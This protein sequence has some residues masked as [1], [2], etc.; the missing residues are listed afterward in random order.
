MRNNGLNMLKAL[1]LFFPYSFALL[2]G[3]SSLNV[4]KKLSGSLELQF[5]NVTVVESTSPSPWARV[6]AVGY[7]TNYGTYMHCSTPVWESSGTMFTVFN[8]GY[9]Q[10][11]FAGIGTLFPSSAGT[12]SISTT[13][14]VINCRWS[15]TL[16][17]S[18]NESASMSVGGL[19][20][21]GTASAK[22]TTDAGRTISFT[23]DENNNTFSIGSL[24]AVRN[25]ATVKYPDQIILSPT[26]RKTIV[27]SVTA[28]STAPVS[29]GIAFNTSVSISGFNTFRHLRLSDSGGGNCENLKAGQDCY[30]ELQNYESLMGQTGSGTLIMVLQA[31]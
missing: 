9:K 27:A 2:A 22:L 3:E 18:K 30:V 12:N 19:S 10:G 26:A 24:L 25:Q 16:D 6:N 29:V 23:F 21:G 5:H 28:N 1:L 31:I 8:T 15:V 4:Q 11:T 7:G 13:S 14:P 20:N 17:S